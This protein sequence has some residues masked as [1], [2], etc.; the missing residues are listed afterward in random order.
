[1]DKDN[2]TFIDWANKVSHTPGHTGMLVGMARQESIWLLLLSPPSRSLE[3]F[4]CKAEQDAPG[5]FFWHPEISS[6][7]SSTP[8]S[9]FSIHKRSCLIIYLL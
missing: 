3:M 1:M 7:Q 4:P 5:L 6:R 9:L 2:L 8:K